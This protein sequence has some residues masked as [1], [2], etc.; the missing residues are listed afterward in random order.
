M[1][2]LVGSIQTENGTK[3]RTAASGFLS[4]LNTTFY[5]S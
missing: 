2:A 5:V 3:T 4:N 1:G